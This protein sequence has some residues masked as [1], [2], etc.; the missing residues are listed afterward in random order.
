[1]KKLLVNLRKRKVQIA[2]IAI[3]TISVAY[4]LLY[5]QFTQ[6]MPQ[7]TIY[8]LHDVA[9]PQKG[10]K[11]LVYSPHPD[12]E[13]IGAAGYIA[14]AAKQGAD[15]RIILITDG[16]KHHL[17]DRRYEEF[18]KATGTLGVQ[19][20][21]LVFLNYPDGKL[22]EQDQQKLENGLKQ[23][24]D[25]Y[26]PNIVVYPHPQD[27]HPDHATAGRIVQKILKDKNIISYQYLVHHNRFPQPKKFAPDVYLLP[28][29]SMVKF[30]SEWQRYIMPDQIEDQKTEATSAYKS[31][32]RIPFLRSLILSSIR[33]NELF[34]ITK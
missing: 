24:F 21:N 4:G 17:K 9:I 25:D 29:I 14:N 27:K 15:V 2:I 3:F 22:K 5:F 30:D 31:Q 26:S 20:D 28:P 12:D 16:S 1:M 18:K 23:Q 32:L 19:P 8:L 10:Q 34:G 11:V 6:V 33:R 13:T 7:V